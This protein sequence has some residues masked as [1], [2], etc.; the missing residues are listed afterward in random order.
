MLLAI[1]NVLFTLVVPGTVAFYLP[2]WIGGGRD[3][4]PRFGAWQGLAVPLLIA[5]AAIILW[6]VYD[7][8]TAGQGTPLPLDPPRRL[9]VRGL[10]RHM[11]NPMYTGV[12][13]MNLGWAL[14]FE[15]L[16]VLA[17]GVAVWAIQAAFVLLY[18]EPKLG[19]LFGAEYDDYRR[20]VPRWIPRT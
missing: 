9:V 8:A 16:A 10:Y 20:R 18:E 7:F 6:T 13:A 14:L 12:L 4:V 5:G 2:V 15:S 1:K 3:A 19:R 17:Y 11:R